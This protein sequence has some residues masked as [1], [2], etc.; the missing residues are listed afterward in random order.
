MHL[1]QY[2]IGGFLITFIFLNCLSLFKKFRPLTLEEK[3]ILTSFNR[4][5]QNDALASVE[6]TLWYSKKPQYRVI[7]LN[8]EIFVSDRLGANLIKIYQK[9]CDEKRKSL[10]SKYIEKIYLEV[11]ESYPETAPRIE[12]GSLKVSTM[13]TSPRPNAPQPPVSTK[14]N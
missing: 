13:P 9:S 11:M 8:N 14:E 7:I 6:Y 1:V 10:N 5:L 2:F 3:K 4:A 12:N